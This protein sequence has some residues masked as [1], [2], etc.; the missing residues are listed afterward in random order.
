MLNYLDLLNGFP[1]QNKKYPLQH[2]QL[3]EQLRQPVYNFK[4]SDLVDLSSPAL[5]YFLFLLNS[6]NI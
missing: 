1:V 2:L 3:N 6:S 4:E 5:L